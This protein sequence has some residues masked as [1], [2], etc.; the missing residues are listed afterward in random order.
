MDI[1]IAV[2]LGLITLE[3]AVL[4]A[5]LIAALLK[6]RQTAQAIEV[7][8]YRLDASVDGVSSALSSGWLKVLPAAASFLGGWFSARKR[9]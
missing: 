4:V 5:V 1:F 2:C 9:G 8:A 3:L 7:L 6:V